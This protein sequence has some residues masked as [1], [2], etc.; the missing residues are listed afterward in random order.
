MSPLTFLHVS[1]I[2]IGLL[3]G[4]LSMIFRKGSSLH[5][6]AGNVFFG[7]MLLGAGSG[8]ILAAFVH[9][10]RGNIVGSW[11][12][13]YLVMT[14]W[15]AARRRERSVRLVDVAA[16]A[17]VFALGTS[18]ITWGVQA[19]S[20]VDGKLD[21]YPPPLFFVF[22]SIALLFAVADMRMILRGGVA[23]AQRIARHLWRMSLALLFT[24]ASGYPGQARLFPQ[25]WRE[26]GLMYV[27]HILVAG[28]MIFWMVRTLRKRASAI[29]G[30]P[31]PQHA[32]AA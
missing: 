2:T 10:N 30:L 16:L 25:A 13:C 12:T 20:S 6:L 23:G 18:A 28:S 27:P 19:A 4:G 21:H 32:T 7:S 24:L 3:S 14:G 11:L 31:K 29:A 9:L 8:A 26:S 5:R 22:G 1:A 15:L 17:Y